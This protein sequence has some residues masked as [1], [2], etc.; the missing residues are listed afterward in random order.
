VVRPCSRKGRGAFCCLGPGSLPIAGFGVQAERLGATGH[1][2]SGSGSRRRDQ[3]VEAL[4]A[5]DIV[6]S[7]EDLARLG[8]AIPRDAAAGERYPAAQMAHLD[9][10][11][12]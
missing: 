2:H 5:A 3:L 1:R 6:L 12:G 8:A 7:P 4:K 9:S 11:H 10:E